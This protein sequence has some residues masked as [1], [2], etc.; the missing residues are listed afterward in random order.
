MPIT[1]LNFAGLQQIDKGDSRI[2][3]KNKIYMSNGETILL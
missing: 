1:K 3:L 2:Q